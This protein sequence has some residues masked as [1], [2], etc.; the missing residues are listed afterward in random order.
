MAVAHERAGRKREAAALYEAMV[1][2]NAAARKVLSHRLVT[3]YTQTGQT[4][5]ALAESYGNY[6]A[7]SAYSKFRP[8]NPAKSEVAYQQN[9][10]IEISVVPRDANIRKVIDEYARN[11][12]PALQPAVPAGP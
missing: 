9:R 3:I 1:R 7:A 4:N 10:R 11:I 5:K 12:N 6:F 2:T 8:M